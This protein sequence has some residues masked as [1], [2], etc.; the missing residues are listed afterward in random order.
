MKGSRA[1]IAALA[2]L[3]LPSCT[4]DATVEIDTSP[5]LDDNFDSAARAFNVPVDLLKAISYVETRWQHVAGEE[6]DLGRPAGAG[7]FALWGDNLDRGAAAA[8]FDLDTV[9]DDR[10]A[11]IHAAAARLAEIAAARGIS[12]NDMMAWRPVIAEFAQN[13]DDEGRAAYVDDVLRVLSGGASEAAEDGSVIASI[14][15]N[16]EIGVPE[17]TSL[18]AGGD[19]PGAL[20]RASPNYNSRGGSKVS[21]V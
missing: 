8:G 6:H 4:T 21:L 11:N 19:F 9:R 1:F 14:Q 12:G 20:Y 18:A 15:P 3:C 5:V 13:P 16:I 2:A 17:I 10:D 7:V